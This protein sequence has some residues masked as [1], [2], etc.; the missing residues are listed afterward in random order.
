[1]DGFENLSP[2]NGL[3]DGTGTSITDKVGKD[4]TKLNDLSLAEEGYYSLTNIYLN[5]NS[6]Q[7]VDY[8]LSNRFL[9]LI[10]PQSTPNKYGQHNSLIVVGLIQKQ[11][12]A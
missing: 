2:N 8:K 9:I 7:D 1:M 5:L 4:I 3:K 10:R 12:T 6:N 11:R